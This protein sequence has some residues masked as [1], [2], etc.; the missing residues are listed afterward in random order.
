MDAI[1]VLPLPRHPTT[2]VWT[3]NERVYIMNSLH[4]LKWKE[5]L[6]F[7][8]LY[9]RFNCNY[10]IFLNFGNIIFFLPICFFLFFFSRQRFLAASWP[11]CTKFGT[12]VSSC[13]WFTEKINFEGSKTSSQREKTLKN[14]SFF[15]HSPSRFARTI[16]SAIRFTKQNCLIFLLN[17]ACKFHKNRLK[18]K[19]QFNKMWITQ[20]TQNKN[21]NRY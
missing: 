17:N 19:S 20:P 5:C 2:L 8:F 4:L 15:S 10:A 11:I 21:G 13:A 6:I 9:W 18:L 12:N 14:R 3:S 16:Y 1:K 7:W